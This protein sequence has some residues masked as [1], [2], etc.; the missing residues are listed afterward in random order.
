M[1]GM[2]I[3]LKR[4]TSVKQKPLRK[5]QYDVWGKSSC[6]NHLHVALSGREE[7]CVGVQ[8]HLGRLGVGLIFSAMFAFVLQQGPGCVGP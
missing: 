6:L 4:R 2:Y 1:R 3:Q 5:L 8:Q 7:C